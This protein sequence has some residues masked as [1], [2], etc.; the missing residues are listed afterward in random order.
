MFRRIIAAFLLAVPTGAALGQTEA[1][2]GD[3]ALAPMPNG[4]MVQA[5]SPKG[6]MLSIWG[7]AGE[8][9]LA[10]LL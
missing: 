7:F 9:K 10:F 6:T 8:D 5:T 1:G 2:M 4:C 3:W